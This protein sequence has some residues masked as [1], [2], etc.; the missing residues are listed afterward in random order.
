MFSINEHVSTRLVIG[1]CVAL[2]A[3]GCGKGSSAVPS[4]PTTMAPPPSVGSNTIS[5]V[6]RNEGGGPIQGANVNAWVMTGSFNYSYMYAHGALLT[7]ADGRYRMT[8]LPGGVQVWLQDYKEGYA[9]QCAVG[10]VTVQG[11][12]VIDL[13]LVATANLTATAP[14]VSGFRSLSGTVV[15]MTPTGKAPVAGAFVDFEPVEDFVAAVTHTDQAGRFALCGL[16]ADVAVGLS[17][18]TGTAR[19]TYVSVP[20]GETSVEIILP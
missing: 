20:A 12:R 16:P 9:Q 6:V 4:A 15:E 3:S 1:A 10:P 19:V 14:S 5:G 8:G 17:A 2:I 7:D 18:S 11:D 13:Q